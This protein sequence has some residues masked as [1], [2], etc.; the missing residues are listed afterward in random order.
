VHDTTAQIKKAIQLAVSQ[1]VD[2][3]SLLK[4]VEDELVAT[5]AKTYQHKL[6]APSF[7]DL[8][9]PVPKQKILVNGEAHETRGRG[10]STT[11]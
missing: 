3:R 1:G 7:Q 2:V 11:A 9:L 6:P 4:Q 5:G 10:L 8:V